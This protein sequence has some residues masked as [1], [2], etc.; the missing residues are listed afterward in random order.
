MSARLPRSR[1][2]CVACDASDALALIG[3]RFHKPEGIIYLDGNSLGPLPHAALARFD[4]V[5][6]RQW[7]EG[8]ITSWNKAGWFELPATLGDRLG[9]LIGAAPGQTLVC[10]TTSINIYK[11]LHAALSLRPGRTVILAEEAGFP[12]EDIDWSAMAKVAARSAGL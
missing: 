11:C 8:L 3:R 1:E 5:I 10:D 4:E 6:Q 12:T 7:G 9:A 2:E